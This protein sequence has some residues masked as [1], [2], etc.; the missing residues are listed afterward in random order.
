MCGDMS[1]AQQPL[2]KRLTFRPV[3]AEPFHR[4]IEAAYG[5]ARPGAQIGQLLAVTEDAVRDRL[6]PIQT[7][8]DLVGV[9]QFDEVLSACH[10]VNLPHGAGMSTVFSPRDKRNGVRYSYRMDTLSVILARIEPMMLAKGLNPSKLSLMATD[11]RSK[12]LI[13]NWQRAVKRGEDTSARLQSVA[14]VAAALGVSDIWLSTGQ[15]AK[16][17]ISEEERVL[18][19]AYRRIDP[20][21][22]DRHL[23]AAIQTLQLGHTSEAAEEAEGAVE[24]SNH[25]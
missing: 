11:G 5:D 16:D 6:V 12:D 17:A 15:G 24:Q 20:D 7:R 25:G 4:S 13:R 8:R 19:E 23:R 9:G 3:L 1:V 18:L 22:R 10:A 2:G 14:Q 21:Q